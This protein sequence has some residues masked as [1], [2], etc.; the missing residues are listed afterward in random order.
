MVHL[1]TKNIK[2]NFYLYLQ[3]SYNR[4]GKRWTEHVKYLGREDKYTKKEIEKIIEEVGRNENKRIK[5]QARKR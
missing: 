2:G 5:R 4:G 3:S 1:V